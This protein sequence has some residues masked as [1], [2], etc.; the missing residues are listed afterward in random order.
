MTIT[1]QEIMDHLR[2]ISSLDPAHLSSISA[3]FSD[4]QGSTFN[5]DRALELIAPI[6][7]K[8]IGA[9]QENLL[10][11]LS[12]FDGFH[13]EHGFPFIEDRL[14]SKIRF[15]PHFRWEMADE[16]RAAIIRDYVLK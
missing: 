14:A 15:D 7:S 10:C 12:V 8:Y 13:V 4:F 5:A 6:C 1:I 9:E 11:A 16:H 2:E 3:L